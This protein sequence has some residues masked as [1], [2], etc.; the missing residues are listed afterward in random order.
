MEENLRQLGRD[1]LDVVNLRRMRQ[2]SIAEHF[3]ALADVRDAGLI[4]HLGV[5]DLTVR[6]LDEALAIAPVVCVQNRFSLD[7]R[8][9]TE[10]LRACRERDIAFMPFFTIAGDRRSAGGPGT[11][12]ASLEEVARRHGVTPAQVRLAWTLH[13]G[14]HVLAISGASRPLTSTRTCGRRPP[15]HRRRPDPAQLWPDS[16]AAPERSSAHGNL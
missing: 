15:P 4:R 13:Q 8:S 3:G 14:P 5:S 6:H 11:P 9:H 1:H 7:D 2:D 16:A 10:L 12:S